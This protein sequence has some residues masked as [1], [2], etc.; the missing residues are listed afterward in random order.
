MKEKYKIIVFEDGS[1]LAT[2]ENQEYCGE[3]TKAIK[4]IQQG[5]LDDNTGKQS[6]KRH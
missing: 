2:L 3:M 6:K 1:I 5:R 4:K